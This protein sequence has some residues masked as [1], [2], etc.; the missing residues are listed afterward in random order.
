MLGIALSSPAQSTTRPGRSRRTT[1]KPRKTAFSGPSRN[2]EGEIR[3]PASLSTR[4]VFET[5]AFNRSATSPD[6]AQ[7]YPTRG[8][9]SNESLGRELFG[10]RR[11]C[12]RQ[13]SR[14]IECTI[15]TAHRWRDTG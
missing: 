15:F 9:A 7:L 13:I 12:P 4:P 11:L 10:L 1:K 3:T 8:M 14:M 2:G 5:G 6:R